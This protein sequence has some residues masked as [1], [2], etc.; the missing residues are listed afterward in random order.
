MRNP[1]IE[2]VD[3][4]ESLDYLSSSAIQAIVR[5]NVNTCVEERLSCLDTAVGYIERLI[6]RHRRENAMAQPQSQVHTVLPIPESQQQIIK[7]QLEAQNE[8]E[9]LE[10]AIQRMTEL[11]NTEL[12][13]RDRQI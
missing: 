11:H 4:I 1:D 12:S 6:A 5:A 3:F 8:K 2:I 10:L 13:D 7:I 9:R